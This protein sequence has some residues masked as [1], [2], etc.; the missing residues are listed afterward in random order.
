[1]NTRKATQQLWNAS[2]GI[3]FA[4][5]TSAVYPRLPPLRHYSTPTPAAPTEPDVS[6]PPVLSTP[7]A[8]EGLS[9]PHW[10]DDAQGGVA[11]TPTGETITPISTAISTPFATA[12]A[13]AAEGVAAEDAPNPT[14]EAPKPKDEGPQSAPF[15]PLAFKMS[16]ET[17]R[18]ARQAPEETP[19]SFWGYQMYRIPGEDGAPD[20]KVKVHYCTSSTT[21]ERVVKQY[22]S[23]EKVLG[24]DLE[25]SPSAHKSSGTRKNVSLVQ[26]ASASRIGLFHIAA[27]PLTDKLVAPSL[28]KVLEDPDVAKLGVSIKGDCRRCADHLGINVRGQFEL[29][30]LYRLVKYYK[31]GEYDLINKRL[32]SLAMQVQDCLGLPLY[33]GS[34]VR[35]SNWAKKLKMDQVMCKL[36]VTCLKKKPLI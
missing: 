8:P 7:S 24:F 21:T 16:D 3:V 25:W 4:G 34:D 20:V 33:K 2:R 14:E 17:F 13:I 18:K 10:A 32:V 22:F 12:A 11:V 35:E 5:A 23:D 27:F 28:K 9:I 6:P 26:L 29:S 31:S 36:S 1:M 15:T 19:E 30:H